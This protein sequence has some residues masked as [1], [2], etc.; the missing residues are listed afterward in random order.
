MEVLSTCH[1]WAGSCIS[2]CV[3]DSVLYLQLH[4]LHGGDS[5]SFDGLLHEGSELGMHLSGDVFDRAL[6]D[7]CQ[8][9]LDDWVRAKDGEIGFGDDLELHPR[10]LAEH[11]REFLV[12]LQV[13]DN[14]ARDAEVRAQVKTSGHVLFLLAGYEAVG[15]EEESFEADGVAGFAEV[16]GVPLEASVY[17]ADIHV[18]VN[19]GVRHA[20][21]KVVDVKVEEAV[22]E[23]EVRA[24][25]LDQILLTLARR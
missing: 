6:R 16:S 15:D 13:D 21:I 7:P 1:R 23:L 20:S 2:N 11:H 5:D 19:A 4:M 3:A 12:G 8:G 22:F 18:E 17:V 10:H 24:G 25:V 14:A 9:L